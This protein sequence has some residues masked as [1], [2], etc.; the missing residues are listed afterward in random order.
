M[1]SGV[2]HLIPGQ[3][4]QVFF[5]CHIVTDVRCLLPDQVGQVFFYHALS[6][7]QRYKDRFFGQKESHV[8]F[9]P[10]T[11]MCEKSHT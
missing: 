6:G 8:F 7:V 10:Y 9:L 11:C 4:G 5:F 2:G 1:H 3:G